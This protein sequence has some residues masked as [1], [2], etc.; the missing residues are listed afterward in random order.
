MFVVDLDGGC[1]DFLA[2]QILQFCLQLRVE[3]EPLTGRSRLLLLSRRFKESE[4]F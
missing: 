2:S 4:E 1:T 3:H